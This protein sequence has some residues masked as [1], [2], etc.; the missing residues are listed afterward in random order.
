VIVVDIELEGGKIK[1]L[2]YT[3]DGE[4]K[5]D[6]LTRLLESHKWNGKPFYGMKVQKITWKVVEV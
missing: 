3:R 5:R 4:T 1:I 6:V 2:D